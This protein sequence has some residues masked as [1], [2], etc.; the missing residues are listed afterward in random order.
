VDGDRRRVDDPGDAGVD[1][2]ADDGASPL[3]VGVAGRSSS[4]DADLGGGWITAS[5]PDTAAATASGSV[6]S[7]T[8]TST[9]TPCG[10]SAVGTQ[11]RIVVHRSAVPFRLIKSRENVREQ[12]RSIYQLTGHVVRVL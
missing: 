3:D 7:P 12:S 10:S 2:G 8:T 1:G 5:H 11:L 4:A 6:M 9:S